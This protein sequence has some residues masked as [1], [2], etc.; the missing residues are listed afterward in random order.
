MDLSCEYI[1][2]SML[3]YPGVDGEM[4]P[5][6]ILDRLAESD[7]LWEQRISIV[8][9]LELVRA[10]QFDDSLRIARKLLPHKHDLIHKAV[11]WVLREVGKKDLDL[12]REFLDDNYRSLPRTTLRYAI[13]R[14]DPPE[15]LRWLKRDR[16]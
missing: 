4:P 9:T 11:G 2:G 13:E 14:M 8:T 7:N 10:R 15:R 16:K 3:L 6:D 1:L 5:R 12:L